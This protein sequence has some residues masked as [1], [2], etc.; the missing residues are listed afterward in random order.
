M[1]VDDVGFA[2]LLACCERSF[3]YSAFLALPASSLFDRSSDLAPIAWIVASFHL[4]HLPKYRLELTVAPKPFENIAFPAV[5]LINA[6]KEFRIGSNNI[7]W[8]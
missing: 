7:L 8:T 1:Q 4:R 6:P 5:D 3:L 2:A